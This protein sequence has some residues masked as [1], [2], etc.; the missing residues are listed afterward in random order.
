[1]LLDFTLIILIGAVGG[2]LAK[3][4]K[5]P[6]IIGYLGA[7]FLAT[8]LFP[9]FVKDKEAIDAIAQIGVALLVFTLGIE[10][11]LARISRVIKVAVIGGI[12]QIL[13]SIGLYQL[14]LTML[15]IPSYAALFVAAGFSLSST[16]VVVK[17]LSDKNMLSSLPGEIMVAWLLIQDLAVVPLLVI[18]PVFKNGFTS[19]VL[20]DL[21]FPLVTAGVLITVV[22]LFGR[23]L[24]SFFLKKI[25]LFNSQELLLLATLS[26]CLIVAGV[27][28][29]LGLSF[30]LG[31]FLAGVMVGDSTEHHAM[32]SEIRSLRDLFT[33]IFFVS[34]PL[35][36]P[37]ETIVPFLPFALL[38]SVLVIS[39]KFLVVAGI[40]WYFGYHSKVSFVV[41]VGL[42]QVGEF[43][44]VLVREGLRLD[45]ITTSIYS[46]VLT[47][48]IIT[49][50]VTPILFSAS[51]HWYEHIRKLVKNKS[52]RLYT[53]LFT[54]G[55]HG[56]VE[57]QLPFRDHIVLLGYGRMG[58]YIG[59][60]LQSS[61]IPFV[62]VEFN[63]LLVEKLKKEKIPVVY[64]DPSDYEILDFAQV[65]LAR[66]LIITIPDLTTQLAVI[67]NA[68]KLNPDITIISRVHFEKDQKILKGVGAD[69]VVH[70]EFTASLATVEK[71][72]ALFH[73]E[74]DDVVGKI[75]R[76]K[77]EHGME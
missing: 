33:T 38:L 59:R 56:I 18:L 77:I 54:R 58:K 12:F 2:L 15:G 69:M 20:P 50:L 22:T 17:I 16:A 29:W 55:E 7:G 52:P 1:M 14:L 44:F 53:F 65:D 4:A 68:R 62:V 9:R 72:L 57:E 31:A 63:R 76:L 25:A 45:L 42:I 10:F 37:P 3:Y 67:V 43:A 13:I 27:T 34:L 75:A 49:I 26:L 48:T 8:L 41:G 74:K 30:A 70:P 6:T 36:V 11:N 19:H 46:L 47:V 5:Q 51:A 73:Q 40:T 60:A 61:N 71:V 24:T 64:G 39:I 35:L 32:F 21:I 28:E 23:K 66:A